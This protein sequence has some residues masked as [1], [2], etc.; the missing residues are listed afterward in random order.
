MDVEGQQVLLDEDQVLL[1]LLS[2]HSLL[3]GLVVGSDVV[4]LALGDDTQVNVAA[5]TQVVE[6]AGSDGVAHQLLGLGLLQHNNKNQTEESG[7]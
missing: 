1:L 6:D 5:G 3:V 2:P 4:H 7:C